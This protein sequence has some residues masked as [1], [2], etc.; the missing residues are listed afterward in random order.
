MSSFPTPEGHYFSLGCAE[1]GDPCWLVEDLWVAAE[2][3]P[4]E[5]IPIATVKEVFDPSTW[6]SHWQDPTHPDVVPELPRI[7]EADTSY[8]VILHPDGTLMDGMHRIAKRLM[9]GHT[10]VLSV[11]FTPDTLPAPWNG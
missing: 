3:L 7:Q 1:D 6:L 2:G 8:P 5:L 9:E 4:S 10:T 11:R